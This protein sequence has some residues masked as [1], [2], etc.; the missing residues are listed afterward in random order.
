LI[1]SKLEK[2]L[3][4]WLSGAER[5]VIVGIG[6]P[7]R[8]D[9]YVGVKIVQHLQGKVSE[10]VYLIEC[11]TAPESYIHEIVN[12]NPTHILIVDA[13]LLNAKPGEAKLF[14]PNVL[15]NFPAFSTH[16]LPLRVFCDYL[17]GTTGAK[18]VLLL[19]QPK[20]TDFGEGLSPE[21][22]VSAEEVSKTLLAVLP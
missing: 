7:I 12:F 16:I 17:A 22:E 11:E 10:K 18:I 15:E 13:A 6:N 1:K 2:E 3:K 21:V 19:I 20:N 8:M 4:P 5:V 14:S 9:D